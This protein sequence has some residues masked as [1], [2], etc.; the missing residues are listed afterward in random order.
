MMFEIFSLII[1]AGSLIFSAF[2]FAFVFFSDFIFKI[3]LIRL[4]FSFKKQIFLYLKSQPT[5]R[6]HNHYTTEPTVSRRDTEK[7]S[8]T[9]SHA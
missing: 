9:F 4:D 1:F 6:S 5:D 2:M 8:V 3:R 7:L